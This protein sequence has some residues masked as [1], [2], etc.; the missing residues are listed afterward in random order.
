LANGNYL[1][2]RELLYFFNSLIGDD[3][4]YIDWPTKVC[5]NSF[6]MWINSVSLNNFRCFKSVQ[7]TAFKDLNIMVGENNVGKSTVFI[8]ISKLI[9]LIWQDRQPEKIFEQ[10]DIRYNQL[11]AG[12]LFIRCVFTL[13]QKEKNILFDLLTPKSFD[14]TKKKVLLKRLSSILD[15]IEASFEWSQTS[16]HY[17]IK[18][19]SLFVNGL[20]IGYRTDGKG[21]TRAID[22]LFEIL[23]SDSY[24]GDL[25]KCLHL[26]D[27]W[28]VGD[29]ETNL[30]SQLKPEFAYFSEFR[31]RPVKIQRS[32]ALNSLE[33]NE[34]AN[35]LL[36]LKNHTDKKQRK[37]YIGVKYAFSEFFPTLKIEAV[38]SEPG[39]GIADIQFVET[40]KKYP[41]TLQNVGAGVIELLTLLT[42]LVTM[43]SHIFVIEEPELHLH[44]HAKRWLGE[45]IRRSAQKNQIF[46]ITHDPLFIDPNYIHQ[47]NRFYIKDKRKGTQITSISDSLTKRDIGQLTTATK[48]VSKCE[49]FFARAILF[50]ED[51]SQQKFIVECAKKLGYGL[52]SMGL[53]IIEVGGKD[54]FEP[55]INLAE[56]VDIPFLCLADLPWGPSPKRPPK[57]Y[58]SLGYELEEYFT[59][60]GLD[61][62]MEQAKR[63]VGTSK[64]RVARYCGE[65]LLMEQIPPIISQIIRDAVKLC[66]KM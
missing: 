61:S 59:Q 17:H 28:L 12:P 22:D 51:E 11:T 30:L 39:S 44:P 7:L 3:Y 26:A 57:I 50:V 9:K 31:A 36:N 53:S 4:F 29:I 54:G 49:L 33:G 6:T 52:D 14:Q 45:L 1:S 10:K 58:Y 13:E 34:T 65:N 27:R 56:K 18:I 24:D 37:R 38:E 47:L 64:P 41:V 5:N 63:E 25:E 19:G 23:V 16:M 66:R 20:Y 32:H 43:R 55:Y 48:D 8:A 62:L 46:I 40:G 42:N 60:C 21:I 2:T 15:Y 35:V